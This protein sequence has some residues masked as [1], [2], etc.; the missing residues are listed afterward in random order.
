[1]LYAELL[2]VLCRVMLQLRKFVTTVK[3]RKAAMGLACG[4]Y[5]GNMKSLQNYVWGVLEDRD[6]R[7]TLKWHIRRLIVRI[8]GE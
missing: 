2:V 4:Y 5:K 1:M 8:L 3:S 7:L 6:G